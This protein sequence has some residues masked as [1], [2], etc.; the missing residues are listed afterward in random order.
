M[1]APNGGRVTRPLH[2]I[3]GVTGPM[4]AAVARRL[5]ADGQRVR[6]VNRSGQGD[7]PAGVPG[8]PMAA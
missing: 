3:I 7:V 8:I 6:G 4:G 1:A 5:V 2:V